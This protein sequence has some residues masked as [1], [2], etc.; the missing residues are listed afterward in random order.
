MDEDRVCER[1]VFTREWGTVTRSLRSPPSPAGR[2]QMLRVIRWVVALLA[3]LVIPA[4]VYYFAF[5]RANDEQQRRADAEVSNLDTRIEQGRA[6]QRK[7]TQ[8]HE[9]VGRLGEQI[10]TLQRI[11]P[12]DLRVPEI[13]D[14]AS[15]K[16]AA[17]GVQLTRF[18][19][20]QP[21]QRDGYE[22][23]SIDAE[24]VGSIEGIEK[25]FQAIERNSRI[26]NLSSVTL[27]KGVGG[28]W[29]ASFVMTSYAQR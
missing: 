8:F 9:E 14:A 21:S 16:A 5:A 15:R 10:V 11:L 22:E 26:I 19:A 23:I 29:T 18:A 20:D 2:R 28:D 27:R 13:H 24:V 6:A 1:S 3:A 25:F 4:V 7:L 12:P 17:A